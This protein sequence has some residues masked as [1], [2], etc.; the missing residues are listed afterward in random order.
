MQ[1]RAGSQDA[2][3]AYEAHERIASGERDEMLDAVFAAWQRDVDAGRTSM[4]I[5]GD[6]GTVRELNARARAERIA[7]GQV[8][9]EGVVVAEG[10]T[11]GAG[12]Q[13]R[14]CQNNRRLTSGHS[15]VR[16]G[17]RWSVVTTFDDGAMTVKRANGAGV[18]LLPADYARE[19]VELAYASTAHRAQGRTV[20]TA[21]ALVSPTTTP[22]GALCLEYQRPGGQLALR[23]H[24][25]RPQSGD[26]P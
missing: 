25:L 12:D 7:A 19:H 24:P 21:D 26:L 20:D 22:R 4:M 5:A 6:L 18:V 1:L 13:V 3:G 2:I 14:T 23:G 10:A 11:A 8:A 9:E 17:D 15:W 16:N